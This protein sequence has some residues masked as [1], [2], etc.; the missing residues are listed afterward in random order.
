M[1]IY[2][3]RNQCGLLDLHCTLKVCL[4]IYNSRNQCGL[5]DL[6]KCCL[7]LLTHLQQQKLVWSVRRRKRESGNIQHLQQQKLVWSVR[8]KR[9]GEHNNVIYNSRNQCGLLDSNRQK[10]KHVDD[11]Q[12]QKLVWSVRLSKSSGVPHSNLQQQKLVWSV[13]LMAYVTPETI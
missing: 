7:L 11:L 5:L 3:S 13:R 4:R 10:A 6:M 2:N 9:E 12:Q 8:Q 1:P